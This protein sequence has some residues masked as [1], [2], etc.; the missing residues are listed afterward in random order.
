MKSV[1]TP[2]WATLGRDALTTLYP[3]HEAY[4]KKG[5]EKVEGLV[6]ERLLIRTERRSGKKP[7]GQQYLEAHP[8]GLPMGVDPLVGQ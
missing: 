2:L 5:A 6:K 1:V 4:V 7:P 8:S 3:T